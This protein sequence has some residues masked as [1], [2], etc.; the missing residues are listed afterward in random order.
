MEKQLNSSGI[1]SQDFRHCRFFKRSTMICENETSNLKSS[2]TGSSSCQCSTTSIGQE[3]K[4]R[5]RRNLCFEFRKMSRNMRKILART[6]K[7]YG[8]LPCTPEGNWDSKITSHPVFKSISALSRGILKKKITETPYTL[9]RMLQTRRLLF[10]IIN[11]V[12]SAQYLRSSC[13]LVWTGRLD[14]GR[15]GTRKT[16][17]IR[18]Q[19]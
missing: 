2:R 16:E 7:W 9:M 3:D 5:K 18:D 1:F 11:S 14:R 19:R 17:R 15:K 13:E 8:T 4:K 6:L 12:K 10:R